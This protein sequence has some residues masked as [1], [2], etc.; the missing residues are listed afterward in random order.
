MMIEPDEESAWRMAPLVGR[1]TQLRPVL[2]DDVRWL[3]GLAVSPAIRGRWRLGGRTPAPGDFRRA[4]F[5]SSTVQFIIE[6]RA[7]GEAVGLVQAYA[8]DFRSETA[9]V[10]VVLD[11]EVWSAGWPLEAVLLFL[12]YMFVRVGSRKL[13]FDTPNAN[14]E[15]FSS[16][17]GDY[18][19]VEAIY[20]NHDFRSSEHHDRYVVSLSRGDWPAG[21]VIT[22][23]TPWARHDRPGV[24]RSG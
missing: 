8:I 19:Q 6:S 13:Y 15:R 7:H 9:W 24:S 12:H 23:L 14:L 17:I 11:E 3:Y 20:K 4:L 22:L 1:R 18:L 16:S 2:E 5:E 10:A 21:R